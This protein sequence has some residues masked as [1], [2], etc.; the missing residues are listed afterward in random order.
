MASNRHTWSWSYAAPNVNDN[1]AACDGGYRHHAAPPCQKWGSPLDAPRVENANNRYRDN[2]TADAVLPFEENV[3][4][5]IPS[6]VGKPKIPPIVP[7]A[8]A[9][10]Y[11]TMWHPFAYS[12][13]HGNNSKLQRYRKTPT[14]GGN[15]QHWSL[16]LRHPRHHQKSQS[17]KSKSTPFSIKKIPWPSSKA[18]V[19]YCN[20]T[21]PF[22][23]ERPWI[24]PLCQNWTDSWKV[25]WADFEPVVCVTWIHLRAKIR[26][27]SGGW[28]RD[29]MI[30]F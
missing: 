29:Q 2:R 26:K 16:Q 11:K 6:L 7:T 12:V 23:L 27:I 14:R 5:F 25:S 18:R 13:N 20:R 15:L 3:G 17:I 22:V 10:L 8:A 28:W 4:A 24:I 21:D 19:S 30:E 9:P 1:G